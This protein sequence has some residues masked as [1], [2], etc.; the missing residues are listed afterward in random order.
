MSDNNIVAEF[1]NLG[2][3]AQEEPFE[4]DIDEGNGKKGRMHFDDMR[5]IDKMRVIEKKGYHSVCTPRAD[6][7]AAFKKYMGL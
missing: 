7:E 4:L 1:N 5:S 6:I 3:L 2:V